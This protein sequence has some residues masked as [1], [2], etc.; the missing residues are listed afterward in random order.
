MPLCQEAASALSVTEFCD[1]LKD[2]KAE[3]D[4]KLF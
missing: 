2:G 3:A 1:G 4:F